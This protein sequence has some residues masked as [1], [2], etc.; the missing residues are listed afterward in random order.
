MNKILITG[1]TGQMG[2]TVIKTLLKKIAPQQI[3]VIFRKEEKLAELKS[4][5]LN[6]FVGNYDDVAS[7]EK[8]MDAVD[9]VLLISSGD[10][11]DPYAGT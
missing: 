6:T 4:K 11:G 3:N 7:L 1:A 10:Q 5:G 2:S 8:A 9:T